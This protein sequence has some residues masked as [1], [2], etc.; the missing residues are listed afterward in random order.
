MSTER[1]PTRVPEPGDPRTLYIVDLSGYV[2]RAYHAVP[3]LS[4]ASGEPTNAIYGVT[5]MLLK[6]VQQQRPAMLAVAMDSRTRSF[7]KDIYAEYKATRPEPPPD[8]SQQMGRVREVV[9]AYAVPVFQHD[10]YEADDLIAGVVGRAR[11]LELDVV[12]VSADKDL[13]QLVGPH[14]VMFDTMRDKVFGEPETIEKLGVPPGKVVDLLALMGDSSDN[15]PGVPSVGPKTAAQLVTE[16]GD[17]DGVYAH[18]GDIK[19]KALRE[20]LEGARDAAYL[21]RQLVTLRDDLPTS[22][23]P[24]ALA[25][26]GADQRKLRALFTELEFTRLLAQLAPAPAEPVTVEHALVHDE[27]ALARVVDAIRAE[28]CVALYCALDGD[29]PTRGELVGLA[30]SWAASGAVYIPFGHRYLGVQSQLAREHVLERLRPLLEDAALP[31]QS[32]DAKRDAVALGR[33]G[34]TLRGVELDTMIA[35]YLLDPE[36]H[37]HTLPEVAHA[38]LRRT[39]ATYDQITDKQ[40]GSQRALFDVELARA[41]E[42]AGAAADAVRAAARE[43]APRIDAEG[44]GKLLRDVE[45][46]LADV[47]ADMERTGVL[48]DLEHLAKLSHDVDRELVRLDA[49]CKEL[50]GHDFNVGSPRQLET[51]LFDELKLPVQKRTKTARSTD[52]EVLEELALL[53]PLPEAILEQRSI[54]KL[55]STYLDAL[56]KQVDR[57]THRIHTR[58]NQA[59]AATGRL[60]SS[61]PNLQNIPIRTELGRK[62]R[63]AFI[64]P[65]GHVLLSADY[66]QIELRVLAH[67]SHDPLL[68]TAFSGS[69][70]VHAHTASAIFGI[71]IAEVTREMRGR[72]KTVNYAVI[73]GQTEFALARNLKI[74]RKEA[75]HYIEAFFERY[76][77]VKK[78]LDGV[79]AQAKQSGMVRTILGRRRVLPDMNSGNR[80]LRMAAERVARTTPIQGSA[81]DIMKVAMVRVHRD[82]VER[83]LASRMLLTVHDELV[84][85]VPDGELAEMEKLVRE[86]M[87]HA[88]ALDVRLVV[89]VGSGRTWGQAH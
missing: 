35:S 59:V 30:L 85:E 88:I 33:H 83:R 67:L 63:D 25:Y 3:P 48:L 2:F 14:V 69:E 51:I 84:F 57:R 26:G 86:R 10:G 38:E 21:S 16:Y 52:H 27:R 17:V 71:P 73:Y 29:D 55:K 11:A 68:V 45:L 12:V 7:R 19:R 50:A 78:F 47:L 74:D 8:L 80:G 24:G 44:F 4:T 46:P 13:L 61:D 32:S 42:W 15:V 49:K 23:D 54:S 70:D 41:C 76:A 82:L 58:Y 20:K 89:D 39:L 36:R 34:V 31:K 28:G 53:H 56:P 72:A 62:I 1:P 79:V 40:R 81:A 6:L 9:E 43:M 18:L 66:S 60:S 87:E 5:A 37:G 64:A 65:P 75:A 77:G 22:I